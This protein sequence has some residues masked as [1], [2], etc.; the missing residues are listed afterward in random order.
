[1]K[2]IIQVNNDTLNKIDI[3]NVNKKNSI[4]ALLLVGA[5]N[6]ESKNKCILNYEDSS[7]YID[8]Q[9]HAKNIKS[10]ELDVSYKMYGDA[11]YSLNGNFTTLSPPICASKKPEFSRQ[12]TTSDSREE[13]DT[14]REEMMSN[15]S[16]ASLL[17][18]YAIW[19]MEDSGIKK[20]RV[21]G[22]DRYGLYVYM[23]VWEHMGNKSILEGGN[24]LII[25]MSC[26]LAVKPCKMSN[27]K[28]MVYYLNK[29]SMKECRIF[30][31]ALTNKAANEIVIK[32]KTI[33]GSISLNY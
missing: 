31:E 33:L 17:C 8:F 5:H 23:Q 27:S 21:L 24:K 3:S 12:N 22:I 32:I 11:H 9:T 30:V 25:C 20:E 6:N 19:V 28:F 10:N 4:E 26:I 1:M 7:A 15:M 16:R 29:K 2:F 13:A 18:H 14:G